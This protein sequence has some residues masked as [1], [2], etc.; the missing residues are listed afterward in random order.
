ME[1]HV[2]PTL[3]AREKTNFNSTLKMEAAWSSETSVSYHITTW[4]H[5]PKNLDPNLHRRENVVSNSCF[6]YGR[7]WVRL[8]T[9]NP[10]ITTDFL[11]G[12]FQPIEVN[13]GIAS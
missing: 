13:S 1:A 6:V 4:R 2:V 9:W 3:L 7:S 10:V 12:I 11:H 8:P 5:N